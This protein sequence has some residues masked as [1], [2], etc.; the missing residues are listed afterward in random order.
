MHEIKKINGITF[1]FS[2]VRDV[3]TVSAGIFI[4]SGARNEPAPLKGL[5]HFLEHLVFK[6]S[7]KYSYRQVKREIEG[8]GGILNGFTS[9]EITAY[10]A[11]TLRK[12][13]D[14]TLDILLDMVYYPR[15]NPADISRERQV[16]LEEIKMYNDLPASRAGMLL[17]RL[18]WPGHPL[19]QEVTGEPATVKHIKR[20]DLARFQAQRYVNSDIVVSLSGDVDERIVA[21]ALLSRKGGQRFKPQHTDVA[22]LVIK[23]VGMTLE[24]RSLQQV[25]LVFGFRGPSYADQGRFTAELLSV[26]LGGNMSSRLFEA[27]REKQG[28]CYDIASEAR[29]H[30]DSGLFA[31]NTGLDLSNVERALKSILKELARLKN[32]AVPRLELRRAKDYLLGHLA[33]TLEKPQGRMFFLAESFL[34]LGRVYDFDEISSMIEDIT[35][36]QLTDLANN[37]FDFKALR[38]A[39]VGKF[40]E[41]MENKINAIIRGRANA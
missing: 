29:R 3:E 10:Y 40:P 37:I 33:M 41:G 21:G 32:D 14:K 16:V 12:N 13:L 5:A 1:I 22:P 7:R 38:L 18:I 24:R 15:L 25:Q 8:R 19:G 23:G 4:G 35:S 11:T 28:L 27:V 9:Q 31:V 39:G 30:R 2:P 26:I 6:G 20:A 34:A 17:D 36:P